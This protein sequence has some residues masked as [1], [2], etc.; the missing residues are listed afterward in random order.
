MKLKKKE[1]QS[2]DTS[3]L[4]KRG[5]RISME[6]VSKCEAETKGMTI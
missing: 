6:G 2:V 4:L 3:V 1:K 5:N